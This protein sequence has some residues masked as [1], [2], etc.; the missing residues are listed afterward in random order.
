MVKGHRAGR[1]HRKRQLV[2]KTYAI[3]HRAA[4]R[5]VAEKCLAEAA[6]VVVE[7]LLL[8]QFEETPSHGLGGVLAQGDM[9][10]EIVDFLQSALVVCAPYH[11]CC[12]CTLL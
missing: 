11:F 12:V 2:Q 8:R 9:A 7:L 5:V 3:V 6:Q 10:V 1:A 4:R